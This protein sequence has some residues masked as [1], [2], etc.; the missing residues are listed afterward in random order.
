[1]QDQVKQIV[2]MLNPEN[3]DSTDAVFLVQRL[4][5]SFEQLKATSKNRVDL[6][7][8]ENEDLKKN[9]QF[10]ANKKVELESQLKEANK[11]EIEEVEAPVIQK[12]M[13]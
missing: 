13:K 1:M 7:E 5:Q 11:S 10:L 8:A 3:P 2:M 6:L 12:E 4:L 9:I